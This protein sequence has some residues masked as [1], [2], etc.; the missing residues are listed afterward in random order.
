MKFYWCCRGFQLLGPRAQPWSE[1]LLSFTV[2]SSLG[3]RRTQTWVETFGRSSFVFVLDY[4][5]V[6]NHFG[7]SV[8]QPHFVLEKLC[9]TFWASWC[10]ELHLLSTP[11]RLM[12][13]P[14]CRSRPNVENWKKD[15]KTSLL[16]AH[17]MKF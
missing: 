1:N 3:R 12:E 8:M 4:N 15:V 16:N 10:C 6:K 13:F 2:P 7:A 9:D 17:E 5:N 11:S 14:S